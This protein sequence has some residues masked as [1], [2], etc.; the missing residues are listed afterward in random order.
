M[1]YII[2]AILLFVL[3]LVGWGIFGWIVE[4]IM[5]VIDLLLEGVQSGCSCIGSIIIAIFV[6][7]AILALFGVI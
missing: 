5:W 6:I 1:L 2:G 4:G 7:G 3:L